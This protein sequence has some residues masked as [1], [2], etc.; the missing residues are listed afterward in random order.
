MLPLATFIDNGTTIVVAIIAAGIG[1]FLKTAISSIWK[2]YKSTAPE[3][4]EQQRKHD[5][6]QI[7]N[8]SVL[9]A[10]NSNKM[11]EADVARLRKEITE[12]NLRHDKERN[13]W[14][15]KE[16]M[17]KQELDEMETKWRAALDQLIEFKTRNGLNT[18]KEEGR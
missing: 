18:N 3:R 9:V 6:V 1:G 12:I 10:S 16:Q 2:R 17:Y 7:A 8:D 11:L 13:D 15:Q 4:L 5:A 14:D